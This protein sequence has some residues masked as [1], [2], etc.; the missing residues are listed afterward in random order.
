MSDSAAAQRVLTGEPQLAGTV[1]GRTRQFLIRRP[2]LWRH[3]RM[4]A[5]VSS[6][7]VRPALLDGRGVDHDVYHQ[8]RVGDQLRSWSGNPVRCRG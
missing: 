3:C 5:W 8:R 7:L 2:A 1:Q 6:A 4:L